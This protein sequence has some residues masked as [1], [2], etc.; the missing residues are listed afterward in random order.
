MSA[1]PFLFLVLL[2][3][4]PLVE[5]L[6]RYDVLLLTIPMRASRRFVNRYLYFFTLHRVGFPYHQWWPIIHAL[7]WRLCAD[8]S[9]HSSMDLDKWVWV[10]RQSHECGTYTE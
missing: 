9:A 1:M 10:T 7:S 6:D 4:V 3:I 2:L 5:L 8:L